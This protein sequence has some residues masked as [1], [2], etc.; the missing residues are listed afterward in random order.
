MERAGAVVLFLL[1][2]CFACAAQTPE[3]RSMTIF[4]TLQSGVDVT[5]SWPWGPSIQEY[6]AK[7]PGAAQPAQV[8][9]HPIPNC[10]WINRIYAWHR[11]A[12]E[13][14]YI[15][16]GKLDVAGFGGDYVTPGMAYGN[17]ATDSGW[18]PPDARP[19]FNPGDELHIHATG[20]GSIVYATIYYTPHPCP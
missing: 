13:T 9:G 12:H 19:S 5:I 11:N 2:T 15:M 8:A 10:A 14:D 16:V 3:P 17:S 4:G 20:K 18:F 7:H 1:V 6:A